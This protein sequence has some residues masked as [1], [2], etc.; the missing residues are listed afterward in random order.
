[1]YRL[2]GHLKLYDQ[3]LA[4]SNGL[5]ART[6]LTRAWSLYRMLRHLQEREAQHAV[7]EM[8]LESRE[9]AVAEQDRRFEAGEMVREYL[10]TQREVELAARE[11]SLAAS[12]AHMAERLLS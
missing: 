5:L 1:M 2:P 11:D 8:R 3:A 12:E 9:A 7:R 6:C 4:C 10:L